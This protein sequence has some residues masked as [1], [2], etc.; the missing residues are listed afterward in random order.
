MFRTGIGYDVHRFS[1]DINLILGG[2]SI[3]YDFGL[4]GYSDGDVLIHS[5]IDSLLGACSMGDIG[6]YFPSGDPKFEN[7]SSLVLLKRTNEII[8]ESSWAIE[9]IDATIIAEKPRLKKFVKLMEKSIA[10]TLGI[11]SNQINIKSTTTDGLGM[12]GKGEGIS[13]ISIATVQK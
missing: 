4:L 12:I 9:N 7:I 11:L 1:P 3:P 2:V 13:V 6:D 5:I 8:R 10:T